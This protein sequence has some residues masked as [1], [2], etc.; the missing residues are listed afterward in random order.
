MHGR[1]FLGPMR[2]VRFIPGVQLGYCVTAE[3]AALCSFFAGHMDISKQKYT[4]E[5][6]KQREQV[7]HG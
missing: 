3:G 5:H 7:T 1:V 2:D 6:S 4:P